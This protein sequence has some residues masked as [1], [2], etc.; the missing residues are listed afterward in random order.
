MSASPS[1]SQPPASQPASPSNSESAVSDTANEHYSEILELIGTLHT[2]VKKKVHETTLSPEEKTM[3]GV[4][5][6]LITYKLLAKD[7]GSPDGS[8]FKKM[9]REDRE[10]M[11][12]GAENLIY[13]WWDHIDLKVQ[14]AIEPFVG[15]EVLRKELANLPEGGDRCAVLA[16][17]ATSAM[18]ALDKLRTELRLL[19]GLDEAPR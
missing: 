4:K 8:D 3:I 12:E 9:P 15:P 13:L 16:R 6:S 11:V 17:R 2:D 7:L 5:I 18:K 1:G 10:E 19:A 14:N